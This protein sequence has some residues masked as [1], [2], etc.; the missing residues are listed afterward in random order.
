MSLKIQTFNPLSSYNKAI[1]KLKLNGIR[2]TKQRM[3]LAK[4]LFE[5]GK[6]HVSADSLFEEVRK[7]DR[8]I[9]LATIYNTLKQFTNIGLLR[10]IV[11][12]QNKSLYCTNKESHYHLY[13]EDEDKVVDIPTKNVNLDI[14]QIPACL[15]LH[16]IDVIVRIRTL[17]ELKDI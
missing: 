8:K 9:S 15:K 7:E 1:N 12:D 14:P 2:P 3:I 4:I 5:N 11:V 17:K 13:I 10:E 6:R 16:N